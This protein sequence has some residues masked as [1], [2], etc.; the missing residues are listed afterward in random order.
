MMNN[1]DPRQAGRVR[2]QGVW[3]QP[4]GGASLAGRPWWGCGIVGG[5]AHEGVVGKMEWACL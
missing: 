1:G 5:G 2:M 4:K 3:G